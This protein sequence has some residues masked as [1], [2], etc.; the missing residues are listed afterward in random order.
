MSG[1][2]NIQCLYSQQL[3]QHSLPLNNQHTSVTSAAA[4][5][6]STV[7]SYSNMIDSTEVIQGTIKWF[8]NKKGYGF[9]TPNEDQKVND[10]IFVHQS[11][12]NSTGF[13]TLQ[14]GM[15]VEFKIDHDEDGKIMAK[16]VSGKGKNVLV[17]LN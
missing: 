12:I 1:P 2:H 17:R 14:A 4:V 13:R 16:D 6:T 10:D 7:S 11:F 8:S 15:E 9:I 5:A 3:S